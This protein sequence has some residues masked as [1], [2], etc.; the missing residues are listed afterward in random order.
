MA[1]LW[2]LV[3]DSSRARVFKAEG[4]EAKLTEVEDLAHP[5]GHL[6]E[7]ELTSDL[8]GRTFDGSGPERH[9]MQEQTPPKRYEAITFAKRIASRMESAR[10]NHEFGKL[11]LV[12]EPRFLGI[13]RDNLSAECVKMI[14]LQVDKNLVQL[15]VREIRDRLPARL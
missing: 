12:A 9:A 5:E 15:G 8:P 13:L 10:N 14:T 7:V 11:V 1:D 4:A 6:H 3:A 2:V